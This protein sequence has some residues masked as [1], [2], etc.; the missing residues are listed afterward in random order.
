MFTAI[1]VPPMD[2]IVEE[3]SIVLMSCYA[4]GTSS[5]TWHKNNVTLVDDEKYQVH[6]IDI[7]HAFHF[8]QCH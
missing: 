2:T 7:M 5:V 1:Q 3:A 6:V 4:Q 8:H